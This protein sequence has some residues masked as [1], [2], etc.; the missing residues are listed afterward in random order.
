MTRKVKKFFWSYDVEKTEKWLGDMGAKGYVLQRIN[1]LTRQFY[2]EKSNTNQINYH[3]VYARAGKP[4]L[5]ETLKHAGWEQIVQYQNW[6]V[7][8]HK[9]S[10]V[11]IS[12]YPSREGVIKRNRSLTYIFGSMLLL[13]F[14]ILMTFLM[15]MTLMLILNGDKA[16]FVPSPYWSL[17]GMFAFIMFALVILSMYSLTKIGQTNRKLEGISSFSQT[18]PHKT[19]PNQRL[20]V[21]R[22]FL[23]FEAPDKLE[24]WLEKM[25]KKGYQLQRISKNGISFYFK[26]GNPRTMSY[27]VDFHYHVNKTY[28]DLQREAGWEL[29]FMRNT[30]MLNW[31]IWAKSYEADSQKPR[32]YSDDTFHRKQVRKVMMVNLLFS[33]PFL[34]LIYMM[35]TMNDYFTWNMSGFRWSMLIIYI[36]FS[37]IFMLRIIRSICYFFRMRKVIET[38]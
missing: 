28:L 33:L 16:I 29:K 38:N 2:F 20:I 6:H 15:S 23:W 24:T 25:E 4:V 10:E 3:I 14:C 21:K 22:R 36:A 26:Q 9:G 30:V 18:T 17:T 34:A 1:L 37:I 35:L 5:T 19:S 11:N 32:I 7:L 8:V 27:C 13:F 12:A 31:F